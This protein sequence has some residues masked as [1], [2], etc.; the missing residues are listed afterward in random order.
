MRTGLQAADPSGYT[1]TSL[2]LAA[3]NFPRVRF[4]CAAIGIN[5]VPSVLVVGGT[6]TALVPP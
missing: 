4:G 5:G 3:L 2:E 6:G 1:N